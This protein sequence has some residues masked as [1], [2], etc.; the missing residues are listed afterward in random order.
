MNIIAEEEGAPSVADIIGRPLL[1]SEDFGGEDLLA[2]KVLNTRNRQ[3]WHR[4]SGLLWVHPL[5]WM[6][7]LCV[8]TVLYSLYMLYRPAPD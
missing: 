1:T 3:G 8:C 6:Q 7:L 5:F 4:C 2:I